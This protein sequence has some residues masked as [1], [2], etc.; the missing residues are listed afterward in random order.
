M[1]I[2]VPLHLILNIKKAELMKK[3]QSAPN[4]FSGVFIVVFGEFNNLIDN[5][6]FHKYETGFLAGFLFLRIPINL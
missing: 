6:G 1:N 3:F 5:I 2:S 4:S